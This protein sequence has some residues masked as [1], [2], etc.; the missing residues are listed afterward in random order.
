MRELGI[1]PTTEAR[2][3]IGEFLPHVARWEWD[4]RQ[5]EAAS[6]AVERERQ[7]KKCPSPQRTHATLQRRSDGNE[8]REG[9]R[10]PDDD[11]P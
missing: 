10:F 7:R 9:K 6:V 11:G 8:R 3:R 1:T 2:R 5:F 4:G